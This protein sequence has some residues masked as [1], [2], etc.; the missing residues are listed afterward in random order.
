M[1]KAL[2]RWVG[3]REARIGSSISLEL[4]KQL[5]V[6]AAQEDRSL[7]NYVRVVLTEHLRKRGNGG[8]I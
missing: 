5:E 6:L 2:Y 3:V 8:R 7:S 1:K 4:F